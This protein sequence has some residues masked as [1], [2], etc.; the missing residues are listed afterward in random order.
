MN[1]DQILKKLEWLDE[2]RR[3]DKALIATLQER[4]NTSDG[5]LSAAQQEIKALNSEVA[6]LKGAVTRL[7]QVDGAVMQARTEAHQRTEALE[8][9]L[10]KNLEDT[11]KLRRVEMRNLETDIES[12]RQN[13]QRIPEL[14]QN[15]NAHVDD[16]LRLQREISV[17]RQS[18]EDLK[19]SLEETDHIARLTDE[20]RRQDTLRLLDLQGEL[21]ALLKRFDEQRSQV[22]LVQN[23]TRKL[24]ARQNELDIAEQ[25]RREAQAAF[26]EQQALEQVER[27]R[28]WKEWQARFEQAERS[29][30]SVQAQLRAMDETHQ[31]VKRSQLDLEALSERVQRRLS[32]VAELQRLSEERFRQ[33][34]TTF[35]AEDQKRWTNYT[36]SQDEQRA[37]IL[38]QLERVHTQIQELQDQ[39]HLHTDA[40]HSAAEMTSQRL[41]SLLALVHEWTSTFEGGRSNLA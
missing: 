31:A 36:I 2:E 13:I 40:I 9:Q 23:W 32:E 7:D 3:R 28:T 37:E 29:F 35:K 8:K 27:E 38:R 6:R 16:N 15:L 41:Q 22:D 18:V 12:L 39:L 1:T 14:Q 19:H 33:E 24:E 26:M 17:V 30:E 34:W 20:S 11:E 4:L 5:L 10:R 21:S 25:E